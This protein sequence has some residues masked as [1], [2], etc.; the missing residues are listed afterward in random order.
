M[1]IDG[2]LVGTSAATTNPDIITTDNYIGFAFPGETTPFRG[3]MQ[4]FRAFDYPLTAED[5]AGDMDDDW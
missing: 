1:Y 4:W 2:N 3:G 5:I